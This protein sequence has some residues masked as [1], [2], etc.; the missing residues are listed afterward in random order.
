MSRNKNVIFDFTEMHILLSLYICLNFGRG[1]PWK[2]LKPYN[3]PFCGFE[4][5]WKKK[6]EDS[7]T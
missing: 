7:N 5:R 1:S 3:N 2:I 4:K 6:E